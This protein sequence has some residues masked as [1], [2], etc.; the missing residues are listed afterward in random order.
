MLFVHRRGL[1]ALLVDPGREFVR[2][3]VFK[4]ALV[5]SWVSCLLRPLVVRLRGDGSGSLPYVMAL[6]V[7][8]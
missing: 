7:W 4:M 2:G 5:A 1:V 8:N 3:G 6:G